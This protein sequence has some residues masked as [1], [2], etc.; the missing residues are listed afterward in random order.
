MRR[1]TWILWLMLALL[2]LRSWAVASMGLPTDDVAP[3][4]TAS[5]GQMPCH[6]VAGD[7]VAGS[8]CQ[9]CDWCHGAIVLPSAW[10]FA[11]DDLPA[12]PPRVGPAR[13]TGRHMP[14]GLD[15]PPRTR[16]A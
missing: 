6:D 15:R 7:D 5:A 8:V 12:A 1:A 9:A 13:D 3:A 14:G 10:T 16:L 11:A 2:P 4:V